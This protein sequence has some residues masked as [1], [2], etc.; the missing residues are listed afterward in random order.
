MVR[1]D[2]G[3]SASRGDDS[4][5]ADRGA[6]ARLVAAGHGVRPSRGFVM[7]AFTRRPLPNIFPDLKPVMQ[8]VLF[9]DFS[10]REI[11]PTAEAWEAELEQVISCGLA[12]VARRMIRERSLRV[13]ASVVRSL[14]AAHFRDSTFTVT[15][16]KS[17]QEGLAALRSAGIP[18][19][20]TKGPGI[21]LAGG[22]I[23]DRPFD[24]LDVVV[25]PPYFMAARR[26]LAGVGYAENDQSIQP[27]NCFDRYCREAVNL[28]TLD[29]GSIDLHHRVSPW[30][31]STGLTMS[32]LMSC[33]QI[34]EVVGTPMLLVAP[35]FNLLVAALHVVSDKGRPGQTNKNLA[36]LLVLARSCQPDTT[37]EAAVEADLCAWLAWVLRVPP[38]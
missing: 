31:W 27:W 13:P 24:D 30:Y 21:A 16:I 8:L 4:E 35:Q 36:D 14:Q 19:V 15:M 34:T 3:F 5:A 7:N 29:G 1:V 11:Q 9:A 28:R 22:G 2:G 38:S 32:K 33:A 18:F 37:V 10:E 25:A 20:I 17:S 12:G 6:K 26:V 23:A